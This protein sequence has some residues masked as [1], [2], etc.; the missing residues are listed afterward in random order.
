MSRRIYIVRWAKRGEDAM[1][2]RA[3]SRSAAIR[4]ATRDY[5]A[6]TIDQDS[7]VA[8]IQGGAKIEEGK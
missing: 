6:E 5:V 2:V 1:L 8:L 4:H 7:L 3:T